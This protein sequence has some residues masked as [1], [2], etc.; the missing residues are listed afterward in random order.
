VDGVGHPGVDGTPCAHEELELNNSSNHPTENTT[1][2]KSIVSKLAAGT[3]VHGDLAL[4]DGGAPP[5]S[6]GA[7][8]GYKTSSTPLLEGQPY[9]GGSGASNAYGYGTFAS[10]RGES[11]TM[12]GANPSNAGHYGQNYGAGTR[13]SQEYYT[14]DRGTQ[15]R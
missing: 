13:P 9:S 10:S 15:T 12:T 14:F 2:K 11:Y 1:M 7:Y 3:L 5:S 4:V 6:S 8:G